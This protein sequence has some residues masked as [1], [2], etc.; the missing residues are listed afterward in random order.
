MKRKSCIIILF[1]FFVAVFLL[2]CFYPVLTYDTSKSQHVS[3]VPPESLAAGRILLTDRNGEVITDRAY[4]NGYYKFIEANLESEFVEALV[5]IEDKNYYSHWGVN[6]PA[7]IRAVRDNFSG[8]RVSGGSTITEQYVKNKYFKTQKRSYLQKMREAVLAVYFNAKMSK[9]HLL[10]IYYHDAYF[11]N[12]LYGVGAALEVYFE[13]DDLD[14][15]TQEETV[16][17]LSLLNNPSIKNLEERYFK[18]YFEQVKKRLGY[19]FESTYRWK[20]WR[21]ENRDKFPFVTQKYLKSLSDTQMTIDAELQEF[22]REVLQDTLDEL[23]GKNVTNG[24]VFAM[25]PSTGEILIYQWSKDFHAED[26][27]GQVDIIG[28]QRQPGSTVK[29]F[30]YLMA[31]EAWAHPDDLVLDIESEYN[32]FQ[33]G[34]VYISE[35]YSLKEYGLVRFKKALGNSFNNATVRLARELGLEEVYEYYETYWFN[36]PFGAEH[37]GYSLV[38][39]NAETTLED[40]VMSYTRLLNLQDPDKFLLY[41]ILSDPDNRDISFGVNSLLSTSIPQAVK[42]GTTSD[43]RDNL[44]VSYHPDLVLGVWVWNND[45]SSMQW[46]TGITGAWYIWHQIIEKAILMWYIRD[47]KI[48]IPEGIEQTSYCLDIDCLRK[49]IIYSKTGKNYD[50]RIADKIYTESDIFEEL[51]AYERDRLDDLGISVK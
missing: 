29:P 1:F 10:N 47:R 25:I 20:L 13:K 6:I 43:F 40:L 35:N 18:E 24:A 15:L 38:L 51:S 12:N 3:S 46:V 27:E 45:N 30:L 32:S 26:I 42:T 2:Y 50:S 28:A 37:Y 4:P 31:L 19:N 34:K 23:K 33:E 17:L 21:K 36:L 48:K 9:D 39:G 7:K 11:G 49:E 8:K 22:S 41:D 5:E 44:V 14:E 16:I